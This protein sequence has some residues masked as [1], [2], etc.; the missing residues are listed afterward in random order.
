[1]QSLHMILH[2]PV[3]CDALTIANHSEDFSQLT[4]SYKMLGTKRNCV[5]VNTV[6][7]SLTN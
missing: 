4:L 2:C 6:I 7:L 3:N 1:M 5:H